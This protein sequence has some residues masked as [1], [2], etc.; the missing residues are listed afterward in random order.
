MQILGLLVLHIACLYFLRLLWKEISAAIQR[1]RVFTKMG[2]VTKRKS[3]VLFQ[4]SIRVDFIV[5]SSLYFLLV[6]YSAWL[7]FQ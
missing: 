2:S 7:I 4:F 5:L 6:L 1:G 3:P